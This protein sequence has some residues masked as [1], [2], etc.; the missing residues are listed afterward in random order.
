MGISAHIRADPQLQC[1]NSPHVLGGAMPRALIIDRADLPSLALL[2]L[3][4]DHADSILWR[5]S[6]SADADD[7][8]TALVR[9][10]ADLLGIHQLIENAPRPRSATDANSL[11]LLLEASDLVDAVRVAIAHGADRVVCPV[12][13]GP[14]PE[15]VGHMATVAHE[16][17]G[18]VE[19]VNQ[20]GI[21]IDLPVIDL[22]DRQILDIIVDAGMLLS[23][24]WPCDRGGPEPCTICAGCRRWHAATAELGMEW[25]WATPAAATA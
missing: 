15:A 19:W 13:T 17:A 21:A 8:R 24:A 16:I 10:H 18:W 12:H 3:E 4:I 22:N 1:R 2:A 14:R 11:D 9:R 7:R 6:R 23:L 20:R 5:C 25:P